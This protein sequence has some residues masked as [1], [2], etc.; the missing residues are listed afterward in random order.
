VLGSPRATYIPHPT[1]AQTT[2]QQPRAQGRVFS[3]SQ[4]EARTSNAVVAGIITLSGHVAR[5]LFDP[6][7]THSFV[8]NAF[9]GKL[10]R[11]PQPLNFQLVISTPVGAEVIASAKYKGCE[12]IIGGVKTLVDL[13]KLGEME[14]DI[15]LGMDLFSEYRAIVDCYQKKVSFKIDGIP[16][17][18]IEG[19]QEEHKIPIISVMKATR[20]LRQDVGDFSYNI[21]YRWSSSKNRG[22]TSC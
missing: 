16:E 22:H 7:A 14:S 1:T 11:T 9:A 17:F 20:L 8:S 10:D 2:I 13:I 3:V 18:T 12:I 4:H 5:T 6:G 15:I 19:T 21:K